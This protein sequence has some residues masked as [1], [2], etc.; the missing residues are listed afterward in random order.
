M[1]IVG[2]KDTGKKYLL[3]TSFCIIL[4]A[5]LY[6][7][8]QEPNKDGNDI[9]KN[10]PTGKLSFFSCLL[11]SFITQTTVGYSWIVIDTLPIRVTIFCQL[12]S[13]IL[14]TGFIIL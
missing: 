12:L 4:F 11:F 14:I 2:K 1:L 8:L 10:L 7:I 6:Y 3:A 5:I 13:I 9:D